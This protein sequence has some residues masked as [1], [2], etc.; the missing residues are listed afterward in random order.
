MVVGVLERN[1]RFEVGDELFDVV[2]D[3]LEVRQLGLEVD[4]DALQSASVVAD[5]LLD[6]LLAQQLLDRVGRVAP[7][8]MSASNRTC[9]SVCRADTAGWPGSRR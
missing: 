6:V 3:A 7:G 2:S 4:L 9:G 1:Q 8:V 5:R